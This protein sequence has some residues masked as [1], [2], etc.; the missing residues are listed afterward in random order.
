[1]RPASKRNR[2]ES[3]QTAHL[4]VHP[5]PRLM[6]LQGGQ[7]MGRSCRIISAGD[8]QAANSRGGADRLQATARN[9]IGSTATDAYSQP[10]NDRLA[11]MKHQTRKPIVV[12]IGTTASPGT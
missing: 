12:M 2:P 11:L 10:E 5:Q 6:V 4:K 7:S 8:R 9:P 1:M 3:L